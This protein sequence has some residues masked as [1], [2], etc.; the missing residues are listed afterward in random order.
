VS[1]EEAKKRWDMTAQ[2]FLAIDFNR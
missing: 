1:A 2:E